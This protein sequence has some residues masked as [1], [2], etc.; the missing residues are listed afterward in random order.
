MLL[1]KIS[2]CSEKRDGY[3]ENRENARSY[4][5]FNSQRSEKYIFYFSCF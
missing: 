3:F 4:I 2:S 5:V 1:I